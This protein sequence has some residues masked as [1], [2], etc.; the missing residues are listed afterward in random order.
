MESNTRFRVAAT[1]RLFFVGAALPVVLGAIFFTTF[2]SRA[3]DDGSSSRASMSG[4]SPYSASRVLGEAQL[5]RD[6]DV[7]ALLSPLTGTRFIAAHYDQVKPGDRFGRAKLWLIDLDGPAKELV[8]GS[9]PWDRTRPDSVVAV[10]PDGGAVAFITFEGE[11]FLLNVMN[12]MS[13]EKQT[14]LKETINEPIGPIIAWTEDDQLIFQKGNVYDKSGFLWQI[15]PDGSRLQQLTPQTLTWRAGDEQLWGFP[16]RDG[17]H[18]LYDYSIYPRSNPQLMVTGTIEA[19]PSVV[20]KTFYV[21]PTG[22]GERRQIDGAPA[23]P[24]FSSKVPLQMSWSPDGNKLLIVRVQPSRALSLIAVDVQ[25][26]GETTVVEDI[27]SLGTA[28]F[29]VDWSPDGS[30]LAFSAKADKMGSGGLY[31]LDTNGSGKIERI[32]DASKEYS[33]P[34]W[35]PDGSGI[36]FIR[37]GDLWLAILDP[38]EESRDT[39]KDRLRTLQ[40]SP[41]PFVQSPRPTPPLPTG[42]VLPKPIYFLGELN[43]FTFF[44][45]AKSD[46]SA[47]SLL[48]SPKCVSTRNGNNTRYVRENEWRGSRLDFAVTYLPPDVKLQSATAS[49]C[50]DDIVVLEKTY[51]KYMLS[52]MRMAGPPFDNANAPR[53]RMESTT[54][55]GRPAVIVHPERTKGHV[56]IYLRDGFSLWKVHGFGL[57]QEEVVKV[58]EG[59]K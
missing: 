24:Q 52:V 49:A 55:G 19:G 50:E 45:N 59:L 13:G 34:R 10:S 7:S 58:A 4:K 33:Y 21:E 12:V 44:D 56:L 38:G 20:T 16:S 18:V 15:S 30:H 46:Q 48:R 40:S 54:I 9:I 3:P 23:F 31:V 53:E 1:I 5:T 32:G 43:G 28:P 25:K 35:L 27:W 41:W 11:D 51:D 26:G 22:G 47:S 17:R 2:T 37:D 6:M 8:E 42:T 39:V 14:L 29:S 57:D 36:L